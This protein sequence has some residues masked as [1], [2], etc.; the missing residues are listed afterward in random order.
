MGTFLILL[1]V[2]MWVS[3]FLLTYLD[4]N[5]ITEEMADK[6]YFI[7]I[8]CSFALLFLFFIVRLLDGGC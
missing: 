5:H 7:G 4:R 1:I 6:R 3:I 2:L 8:I